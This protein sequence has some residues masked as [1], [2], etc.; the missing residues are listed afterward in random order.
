MAVTL[1]A[2]VKTTGTTAPVG[3][4]KRRRASASSAGAAHDTPVVDAAT[5]AHGAPA[6][7]TDMLA[8][9]LAVGSHAVLTRGLVA[10]Q[11]LAPDK[12]ITVPADATPSLTPAADASVGR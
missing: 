8:A 9:S 3:V 6:T 5:M 4:L 7:V 12:L 2:L 1:A 10:R 11:R